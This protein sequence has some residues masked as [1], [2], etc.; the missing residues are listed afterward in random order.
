MRERL[1]LSQDELAKCLGV[2]PRT[3]RNWEKRPVLKKRVVAILN[4]FAAVAVS[5]VM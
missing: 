1:K 4:N 3:I 2:T 5:E